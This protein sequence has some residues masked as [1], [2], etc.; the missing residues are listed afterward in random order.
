MQLRL[1]AH[2]AGNGRQR[3]RD[4][5]GVGSTADWRFPR[6]ADLLKELRVQWVSRF[7]QW[8]LLHRVQRAA[9]CQSSEA[10]LSDGE[11]ERLREDLLSV[12]KDHGFNSSTRIV[13]GQPL[14]LDLWRD[15]FAL[16]GD[17][18]SALIPLLQDGVPTGI[19][20]TIPPSGVWREVDVP[21]RPNLEL[22]VLD[23]PWGSALDDPETLMDL[24]QRDVD[25]GFAEWIH[26]GVEEVRKR[27]G[28]QCAAGRLGL[29]KKDGADPRLVGD[30]TIS[31][32]NRLCRISEK[33]ELPGLGDVE[34]FISR[35]PDEQWVAFVLDV[36]TAH[37]RVKVA[38]DEQGYSVFTAVDPQ[39]NTRWLVYRT[40]HFG[41]AWSAYWWSRVAAG[42]VRL[43]HLLLHRDHF[44]AM[45]VD[46][47]LSLFPAAAAP[48]MAGLLVALACV[49]GIPLSWKK[50]ALGPCVKWVGW[51]LN[52]QGA[53]R[54]TLP[55]D[56]T[57]RIVTGLLVVVRRGDVCRRDLQSLVGL[58]SW[59]TC[60]SSHGWQYGSTCF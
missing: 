30:S 35:H 38:P 41:G 13:A 58:L 55:E 42:Y 16:A 14:A 18:D 4:G 50:M 21:A 7:E 9:S 52:F 1:P 10:W 33:I 36:K 45:Y 32:A 15:L 19:Q 22:L 24:V 5:G 56:K 53:P 60:G 11:I 23:A 28:R 25:C 43:G 46:D 57:V 12:L 6:V 27:F 44:L 37:K 20:N 39:G 8:D 17:V 47:A 51:L 2:G 34:E 31:N 48:L 26:G 40:C 3:L 29:V 54:A 49:L 59:F